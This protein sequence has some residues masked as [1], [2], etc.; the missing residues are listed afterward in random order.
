MLT[1]RRQIVG[2]RKGERSI[3]FKHM[4]LNQTILLQDHEFGVQYLVTKNATLWV[5][6]GK[7]WEFWLNNVW[8]S[9]RNTFPLSG[10]GGEGVRWWLMGCTSNRQSYNVDN[11][12][13]TA[14]SRKLLFTSSLLPSLSSEERL[15]PLYWMAGVPPCLWVWPF[16]IATNTFAF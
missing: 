4:Y 13:H 15:L 14:Q 2:N 11:R 10:S 7:I 5:W 1:W 6:T 3:V 12:T 16:G 9:F 8:N